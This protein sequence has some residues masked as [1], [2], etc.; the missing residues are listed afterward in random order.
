MPRSQILSRLR[1]LSVVFQRAALE[2]LPPAEALQREREREGSTRRELLQGAAVGAAV[3]AL[4]G[5][6]RAAQSGS[7]A[8]RIAVVGA[9]LAG[10]AA[11]TA[12]RRAGYFPEIF[13]ASSRTGGRVFTDHQTFAASGQRVERGGELIDTGHKRMRRL[14]KNLG[15]ALDDLLAA[16]P[17]G[18]QALGYFNGSLYTFAQAEQDFAGLYQTLHRD[19]ID[20]NYP[21]SYA[22]FTPEGAALDQLSIDAWIASRVPGGLGSQ[23]GRLLSVAYDIEY[24]APSSQQSALNLIYLLGFGATPNNF[25]LFG[26]SDER[27]RVRGGNDQIPALLSIPLAPQIR[28]GHRLTAART[29]VDGRT[30][31]TF[32]TAGAPFEAV[33]DRVI[34]TVPF[35]VLRADVDLAQLALSTRKRTTIHQQ[36]MGTNAKLHVQFTTR[37]W[38]AGGCNGET[39]GDTGF[40]N[41]WEETRAQSGPAGILVNYLGSNGPSL[42]QCTPAQAAALFL[43]QVEP[44]LPG[45]S[46]R[47]NGNASIDFWP[48]SPNQRGSY[49]YWKVGQYTTL[50]GS[51]SEVEGSVHFAGEHTSTDYQGYME[52]AVESGERAASE[53]IAAL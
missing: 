52:G 34:L 27:F 22:N 6:A 45:L 28:S 29:L 21:T 38:Y 11:A 37:P 16:E 36:G 8:P 2:G 51:E 50:A 43:A 31:L 25:S 35:A 20:A 7:N 33:F 40:Q 49:A 42:G 24:G 17:Q 18:T 46:T 41:T 9:G 5:F 3:V 13:E 19:V 12:L 1:Q 48:G 39:F 10:L 4:P 44:V 32:A 15:L 14:A 26:E 30:R 47:F 23:F 53:V